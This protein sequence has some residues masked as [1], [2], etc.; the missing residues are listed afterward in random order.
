MAEAESE[1]F[2]KKIFSFS[3][4]REVPDLA[5]SILHTAK[6]AATAAALADIIN[7]FSVYLST[8]MV[9]QPRSVTFAT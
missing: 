8:V 1:T 2:H 9:M 3:S 4:P 7:N 5:S 6:K